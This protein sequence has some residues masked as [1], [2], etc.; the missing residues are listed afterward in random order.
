MSEHHF[1]PFGLFDPQ[2]ETEQT[3]RFLPH[4]FQPGV[5]TFITFRT[6]DSLP[7]EVIERWIVQQQ[8]WLQSNNLQLDI[9]LN[10]RAIS[11]LPLAVRRRFEHE[12]D[13]AWHALLDE[14][15]G[16]CLMRKSE[17][18]EIVAEALLHF[19][20]QRYDM[21]SFVIMPNHVHLLVQFRLPTTLRSQT[22]SWLHYSAVEIN[23]RLGRDGKFWQSEPF[24]HLVR[25]VTQFEYLQ[26]YIADNP[27]RAHLRAGE[28]YYW[29]RVAPRSAR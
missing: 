8:L 1:T 21:D 27:R 11:T 12:R 16:E 10:R 7:R 18:A 22:K 29:S 9:A 13:R 19:D 23:R 4:W 17:V 2:A 6:A 15:H 3:E 25:S 28:Y 26:R 24:D 20:G 5:A 14:C